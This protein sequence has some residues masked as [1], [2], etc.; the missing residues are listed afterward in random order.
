MP[1][2]VHLSVTVSFTRVIKFE[3]KKNNISLSTSVIDEKRNNAKEHWNN[4]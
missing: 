2:L 4:H 3:L 1:Y